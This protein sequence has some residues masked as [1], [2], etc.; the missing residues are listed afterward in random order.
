MQQSLVAAAVEL[1]AVISGSVHSTK[2]LAASGSTRCCCPDALL[3]PLYERLP[4]SHRLTVF[5]HN[6]GESA[7]SHCSHN[8]H[9]S[10]KTNSKRCAHN[11]GCTASESRWQ[12]TLLHHARWRVLVGTVPRTTTHATSLCH[13]AKPDI[14]EE[15]CLAMPIALRTAHEDTSGTAAFLPGVH[16]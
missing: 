11:T 6:A 8:T 1:A 5:C 7:K 9:W 13:Q 12:V 14:A 10:C 3:L 16:G 4:T 2:A 15:S